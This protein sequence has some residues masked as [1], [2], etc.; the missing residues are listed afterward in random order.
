MDKGETTCTVFHDLS[1]WYCWPQ[2]IAT[3]SDAL[4]YYR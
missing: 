3:T 4:W 1:I 2:N